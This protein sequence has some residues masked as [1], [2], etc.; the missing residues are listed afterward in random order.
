MLKKTMSD[1]T[2]A[3]V[4]DLDEN[5]DFPQID[6]NCGVT[7]LCSLWNN[8]TLYLFFYILIYV[9]NYNIYLKTTFSCRLYW[10]FYF[11]M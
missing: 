1:S 2:Y 5:C 10:K 4:I 6:Y 7:T 9:L 8:K 11:F 3:R